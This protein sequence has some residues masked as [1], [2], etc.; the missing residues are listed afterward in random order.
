MKKIIIS[1][2][3]AMVSMMTAAVSFMVND[4]SAYKNWAQISRPQIMESFGH[5]DKKDRPPMKDD[6]RG[7]MRDEKSHHD[8]DD[9]PR[10]DMKAP[11]QPQEAPPQEAQGQQ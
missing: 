3:L 6:R 11:S 1:I 7:P 2:A 5:K 10:K 8:K 9:R 4:V